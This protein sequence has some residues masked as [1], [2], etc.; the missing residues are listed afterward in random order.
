MQIDRRL[1]FLAL[2]LFLILQGC[3]TTTKVTPP[4]ALELAAEIRL[5]IELMVESGDYAGAAGLLESSAKQSNSPMREWLMLEAAEYWLKAGDQA[6]SL[7]LVEQLQPSDSDSDFNL[8]LR[9]LRTE[10]AVLEGDIEQALD[11]MEPP[12]G[13]D[14]PLVLRQHYH[15]N[16]AEI[17]RLSGNL[18][19]SAREL[20]VLDLLLESDIE[21]RLASQ[22]LLVQTLATMTDTALALLQPQP[23]ATLIGWM[24][25]AKVIKLQISDPT[26]L[27]SQF[28]IWRD[29]FPQHPALQELLASYLEQRGLSSEDH[30]AILLPRSGP[31]AKVA[32]AVRDG[33][34]AAWYQQPATQRP[35]L[36]FYDSSEL[37]NTLPIYQ[38]AI[39]Q[40]AKMIVGPLNKDAVKMLLSLELLDHPILALNQVD[41]PDL[42]HPNLF[43][44]GLAPE[45]EAHQVAERA[46]LEGHR[47]ALILT[48]SG[49]WGQRLAESFRD[50]WEAL[51]G[52]VMEQ[53]RYNPKENDFSVPIRML[54]NINE[55]EA[56]IH[57]LKKLMGR[58]LESETRARRDADF[59]FL[60]ARAQ[61]GRQLRPQLK[62][63]HAG[64]I[65]ILS[66]SHIYTGVAQA[67]MD[68]DLGNISFVDTP[69]L[70]EESQGGPLSRNNLEKLIPG[71]KGR[72]ARLY[73]MG[74]DSYNLLTQLQQ[75][76]TQPGRLF[77]GK[78]GTLYLD[79]RNRLHRLLAWAD[80][81]RGLASISG[82]APRLAQ[83]STN[84][85]PTINPSQS[86]SLPI[87][88][89]GLPPI[90]D[91]DLSRPGGPR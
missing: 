54:L 46:W 15:R 1:P 43:Q 42:T 87:E 24:E 35:I 61:K 55:S 90:T 63:F 80:M 66:T 41:D 77:S 91:H 83:P 51:G 58:S 12:P 81:E 72:Y 8:K 16:M 53:Q 45:D 34:M 62:F 14:A 64:G 3:T 11:L 79:N 70:L 44:F 75:L 56:R 25:L 38:Q 69:W 2:L 7:T 85:Q 13:P 67:E 30:I 84:L 17:F 22:Q 28:A 60:G 36:Q 39:L 74:I 57:A 9:M 89:K 29:R 49:Q 65:P 88:R 48:P 47:T 31:Y 59:I 76:Q 52:Q 5:Q 23:P 37:K 27:S 19:E 10:I 82:Y 71:V 21:A 40:G 73:A 18:L 86:E 50:R 32:A 6:M 26:E 78:S 20:D 33:F 68:R 4:E